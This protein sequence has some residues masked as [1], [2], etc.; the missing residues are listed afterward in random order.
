MHTKRRHLHSSSPTACTTLD[1]LTY[2]VRVCVPHLTKWLPERRRPWMPG[3]VWRRQYIFRCH[4]H[5]LVALSG[6][7]TELHRELAWCY[8]LPGRSWVLQ[9]SRQ[10]MRKSGCTH[11]VTKKRLVCELSSVFI[12]F[13]LLCTN[14]VK[15]FFK[16][17]EFKRNFLHCFTLCSGWMFLNTFPNAVRPSLFSSTFLMELSL[18]T[19]NT[20]STMT[21]KESASDLRKRLVVAF[22]P[23]YEWHTSIMHADGCRIT[24]ASGT[25]FCQG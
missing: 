4:N 8:L 15:A 13:L 17:Q 14:V 5:C 20:T 1:I 21:S 11:H 19:S 12:S 24:S 10:L 25:L 2:L 6:C 16:F 9:L 7:M 3:N 22:E 18:Y 23:L